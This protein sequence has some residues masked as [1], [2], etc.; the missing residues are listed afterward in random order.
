MFLP[1][2]AF[3]VSA[4][5]LAGGKSSRMGTNKA[6]LPFEG[7]PLVV[8]QVSKLRTLI[9]D[10][11]VVGPPEIYTSLGLPVVADVEPNLGPLGGIA[12]ALDVSRSEWNLILAVD[13]VNMTREWLGR[14][15]REACG[16]DVDAVV[17]RTER[18]L[19][20][21][22]AMYRKSCQASLCEAL[23]RGERSVVGWLQTAPGLRRLELGPEIWQEYDC[24]GGL[25]ANL[26]TPDDYQRCQKQH[27][28]P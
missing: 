21:L 11:R 24:A 12:T 6:L 13:L 17:P 2:M 10:V 16:R 1:N 4:F 8:R 27:G 9:G 15:V 18:G 23:Q 3:A 22:C 28:Q 5:I 25:F 7:V 20:P 19:E 26:N 14:L